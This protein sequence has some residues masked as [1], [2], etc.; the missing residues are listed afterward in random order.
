MSIWKVESVDNE[1]S[2]R[3][4]YWRVYEVR[5]VYRDAPSRHLVGTQVG[6]ESGRVSSA[7][8]AFDVAARKGV[9]QSGRV[10]E[11]LGRPGWSS[12]GDYVWSAYCRINS[13]QEVCDVTATVASQLQP[14]ASPHSP[15]PVRNRPTDAKRL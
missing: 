6:S 13:A 1:P 12:E 5:G 4:R 2:L 7:I 10:Y 11:L 9:S 14:D 15:G 3:L 8:K